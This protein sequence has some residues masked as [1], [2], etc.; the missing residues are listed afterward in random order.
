MILIILMTSQGLIPVLQE[1]PQAKEQTSPQAQ[2]FCAPNA[3]PAAPV[4][5]NQRSVKISGPS[6][7][8]SFADLS[9]ILSVSLSAET[10]GR[11]QTVSGKPVCLDFPHTL[12]TLGCLLTV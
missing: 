1:G 6:R 2:S 10:S 12:L 8:L 3:V 4:F 7:F 9:G 11:F 5:H